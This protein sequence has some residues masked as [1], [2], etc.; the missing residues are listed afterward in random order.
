MKIFI[1]VQEDRHTDP[2]VQLFST[3][4]KAIAYAKSVME[5]N[6]DQAQF[7][8]EDEMYLPDEALDDGGLL[9]HGTYSTEGDCVWVSSREVDED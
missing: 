2:D 1:V 3:E 5:E 4:E 8:D 7:V 9:F 6:K